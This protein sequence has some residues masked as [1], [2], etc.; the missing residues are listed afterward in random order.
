M[1]FSQILSYMLSTSGLKI[2]CNRDIRIMRRSIWNFNTPVIWTFENWLVQ[3]PAS[4]DRKAVEIPHPSVEFDDKMPA[5]KNKCSNFWYSYTVWTLVHLH[6]TFYIL[7]F[8]FNQIFYSYLPNN[9]KLFVETLFGE[10]IA[11]NN[12][13]LNFTITE[14][15]IINKLGSF[16]ASLH[17]RKKRLKTA[18]II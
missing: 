15:P 3:I 16:V 4:Q 1:A 6:F 18:I 14:I 7:H 10:R 8:T 9:C 17:W 11:H 13:S 12:F 2:D 5:P